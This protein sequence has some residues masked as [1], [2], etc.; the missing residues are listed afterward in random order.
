MT[1]LRL[2]TAQALVRFLMAQQ[3]TVDG[4]TVPLVHGMFAIFGHGNVAGMGEA[5]AQVR[6]R[7][8]TLR[9]HN[10][11]AMAHAAIAY[12]KTFRRRR[13]MA[14]TTSIGPGAT[15]MVTAAALAH[16]NRLPVLLLPGD[17]FA[18]RR[19]DPVLQ[20]VEDFTDGTVSANDCFRP[21]SRYWDR[22]TRP[23]QLLRALPEAVSVLT[24]PA[25]CGPGDAR[26]A[27]GRAGG[28]G[29]F[30]GKLFRATYA[31]AP[32]QRRRPGVRR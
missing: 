32:T 8:P 2:T 3:T 18:S 12:A 1:R 31:R 9:A 30:S 25:D 15:N 14:C 20:Q 24:D 19:P 17:V 28:G 22:I 11:Q 13:L 23:E 4:R 29:R 7:F 21:V 27:A 26:V 16:V 5:L 10:E 6:D